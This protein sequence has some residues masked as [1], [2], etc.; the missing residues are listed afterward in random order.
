MLM[1]YNKV[2]L[3]TKVPQCVFVYLMLVDIFLA[4]GTKSHN[5]KIRLEDVLNITHTS[6]KSELDSYA[7]AL[8]TLTSPI[9]PP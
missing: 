2:L 1:Y 3:E 5:N 4:T 9:R 6:M 7:L 8:V